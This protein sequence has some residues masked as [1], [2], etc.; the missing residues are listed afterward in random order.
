MIFWF[1]CVAA[2]ISLLISFAWPQRT[3]RIRCAL[4]ALGLVGLAATSYRYIGDQ[5]DRAKLAT[6]Q[7]LVHEIQQQ[8]DYTVVAKYGVSGVSGM[9]DSP[10]FKETTPL[11]NILNRYLHF[12]PDKFR[13]DCTP[14]A[15]KA[16]TDTINL[17]ENFPFPYYYRADCNRRNRSGE[18]RH[19]IETA[20]RILLI[21]TKIVGHNKQHDEMLKELDSGK[22][23]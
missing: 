8:Q 14:E 13:Y 6:A 21:T 23:R 19:D 15:L 16:Y 9:Y 11:S 1:G 7:Q 17:D 5:H 20:R 22:F 2:A 4:L 12:E 18:W 10:F 3:L